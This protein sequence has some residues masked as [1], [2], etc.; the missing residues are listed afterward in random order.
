VSYTGKFSKNK[1]FRTGGVA[2][3]QHKALGSIPSTKKERGREG[4]REE[5]RKKQGSEIRRKEG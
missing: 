3:G 2:Q 5:E 1:K 4:G